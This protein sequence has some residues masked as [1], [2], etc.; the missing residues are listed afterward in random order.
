MRAHPAVRVEL[1]LADRRANLVEEGL[2]LAI[3]VG[4]LDDSSLTARR[5]GEVRV[6]VVAGKDFVKRRGRG[7]RPKDLDSLPTI[8][9]RSREDWTAGG[10]KHRVRP[11][12]VVNDLEIACD[13]AVAGLGV[14][15]LP[16]LITG[17]HL[18][19]GTLR[20]LFPEDEVLVPVHV[21]YPS[22][23]FLASKVRVFVDALVAART[24]SRQ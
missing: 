21:V 20:R 2:D 15:N 5:L 13:A 17:A 10:R 1:V 6:S 8:G 12:L 11:T 16:E 22:R 9:M 24:L 14:A 23:E 4:P 7:G 18:E 3:R 19:R